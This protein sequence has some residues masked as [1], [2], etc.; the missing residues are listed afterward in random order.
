MPCSNVPIP[1]LGYFKPEWETAWSQYEPDLA[2]QLLDEIGL[3][4][5]DRDGIRLRS[6][7]D[8]LQ[9]TILYAEYK[10]AVTR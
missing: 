2:N 6:D 7:G 4:E 9:V 3:T 10:Q 5:R 1:S 8:P